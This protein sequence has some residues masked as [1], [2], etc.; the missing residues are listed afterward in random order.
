[1]H[2]WK[3]GHTRWVCENCGWYGDRD[4]T[5]K[6]EVPPPPDDMMVE[7]GLGNDRCIYTCQEYMVSRVQNA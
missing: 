3:K 6:G 4:L 5:N 1:M 2:K 7:F